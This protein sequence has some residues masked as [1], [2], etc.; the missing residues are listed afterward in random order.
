MVAQNL[1]DFGPFQAQTLSNMKFSLKSVYKFEICQLSC[2]TDIQTDIER[3]AHSHRDRHT[4]AR[5]N[6]LS[7]NSGSLETEQPCV[8]AQGGG[9]GVLP[10]RIF[11]N[12]WANLHSEPFHGHNDLQQESRAAARKPRDAAS[13]LFRWSSPTTFTTSIRLAK[14]KLRKRPRF[15]APNMLAQNAI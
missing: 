11:C 4:Q 9:S 13:V 3:Y 6:Y 2:L 14:A 10:P 7:Q 1:I 15:R 12:L 8:L 5:G